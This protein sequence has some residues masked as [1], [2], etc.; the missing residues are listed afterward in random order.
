MLCYLVD[1]RP[2]ESK[3]L[4][5]LEFA[6]EFTLIGMLYY[7][8]VFAGMAPHDYQYNKT[9]EAF[10]FITWTILSLNLATVIYVVAQELIHY[11]K[12]SEIK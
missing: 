4:Q 2:F 1:V 9:A 10:M 12:L 11:H 5:R 3:W 6:N 7:M 8:Y